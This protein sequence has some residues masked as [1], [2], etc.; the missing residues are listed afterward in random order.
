MT[1]VLAPYNAF[2]RGAADTFAA[3]RDM[4]LGTI[5]MSPFVRG[6]RLGED[7]GG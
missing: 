2:H 1:Q 5:A 7:P 4:G 6:W 3:A